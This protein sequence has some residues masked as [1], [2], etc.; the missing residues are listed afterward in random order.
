VPD[1]SAPAAPSPPAAAA[2]SE[3]LFGLLL[4]EAEECLARG[5]VEKAVVHASRAMRERPESLTARS[6]MDRARRELTR[7]RRRERLEERVVEARQRLEQGED[8]A[9]EKIVATVLKLLP[10]HAAA[11]QLF[12]VLKDRRLKSGTAEAEAERELDA[13]G[14]SRARRAAESARAALKAG[15]SFR[16]L[17]TV[18]RALAVTPDDPEL[19]GLYAQSLDLVDRTAGQRSV[20]RAAHVRIL[21]ARERVAAGMPEEGARIVRAVLKEDP[22][23]REALEALGNMERAGPRVHVAGPSLPVAGR[24]PGPRPASRRDPRPSAQDPTVMTGK[25]SHRAIAASLARPATAPA[26][27]APRGGRYARFVIAGAAVILVVGASF[28]FL[29]DQPPASVEP[30]PVASLGSSGTA[31]AARAAEEA[32]RV[33]TGHDP[34]LR[35][36]VEDVLTRYGRALETIDS[37]L[38]AEARPDMKAGARRA[39]MAERKGATRVAT[40]LRVLDVARRGAQALVKV[41]RTEV[42]VAGRSVDR[43]VVEETLRF[44]RE[45][46]AWVLRPSR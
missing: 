33:F 9:A 18:R 3:R 15:W 23:N 34:E 13:V 36:A 38:L 17:M 39:L 29:R 4:F 10:D 22:Q 31:E 6:L 5:N 30:M 32:E 45:G 28:A 8:Q 44:Q 19:L 21:E 11:L 35:R 37:G 20:R 42:V 24:K 43:P 1:P 41:R 7:G 40:D 25:F 46:G 26:T 16:A 27:K 12:S 14:R 2:E